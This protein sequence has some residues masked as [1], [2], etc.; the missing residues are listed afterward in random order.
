MD[1]LNTQKKVATVNNFGK[2]NREKL[3][4][5][6]SKQLLNLIEISWSL[7]FNNAMAH[8]LAEPTWKDIEKIRIEIAKTIWRNFPKVAER[9]GLNKKF[10]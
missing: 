6:T 10:K 7:V 8:K 2:L 1:M 5:M 9:K 3:D 4:K